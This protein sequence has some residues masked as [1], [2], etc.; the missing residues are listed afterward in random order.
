MNTLEI[1]EFGEQFLT[2]ALRIGKHIEN[3]VDFYIGP[4]KLRAAVEVEEKQSPSK[5][6]QKCFV[7]Q[8]TMDQEKFTKKRHHYLQKK[9]TAMETALRIQCGEE[10]PYLEK[11]DKIFDIH[12]TFQDDSDI[13]SISKQIEETKPWK[14]D[15]ERK[16]GDF[17]KKNLLPHDQ[18]LS[19]YSKA[20]DILRTKTKE[21]YQDLIPDQEKI[22]LKLV[23]DLL[24]GSRAANWY[25]GNYESRIEFNL[26]TT[27]TLRSIIDLAAHEGYPGHHTEYIIKEQKQIN[28]HNRWEH[29]YSA[30][31][32]PS[33]VISEGIA[34]TGLDV[35][36]SYKE[37]Y[38]IQM[39]HFCPQL[40]TE[41][42]FETVKK[43]VELINLRGKIY[44]INFMLLA[45]VEGWS[46]D[47]LLNYGIK[48]NIPK[49]YLQNH[50]K[51]LQDPLWSIYGFTYTMGKE[52]ILQKF[53]SRP[54]IVDFKTLLMN[55]IL[56]SD[57]L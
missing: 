11:L 41:D 28:E 27:F 43:N 36:Y 29:L 23:K 46:D 19:K 55:P 50:I 1:G 13:E 9:L 40:F 35:L 3:Y 48:F 20:F 38:E 7:L 12:P 42:I 21:V 14:D 52:L 45:N 53:G 56:P 5:L 26:D 31:M 17:S 30:L 54:S 18:I 25:L 24:G 33:V 44:S 49:K 2:L 6:L 10:I 34:K 51:A 39:E 37:Q 47:Q 32:D 57:L 4:P 22:T 15:T 16:S 8:K